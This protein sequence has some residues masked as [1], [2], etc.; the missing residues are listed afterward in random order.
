ML[1]EFVLYLSCL[2]Y[3]WVVHSIF[4]TFGKCFVSLVSSGNASYLTYPRFFVSVQFFHFFGQKRGIFRIHSYVVKTN[5]VRIF[6]RKQVSVGFWSYLFEERIFPIF[7]VSHKKSR[8]YKFWLRFGFHRIYAKMFS[9][10]VSEMKCTDTSRYR[11]FLRYGFPYL[12][13]LCKKL[14]SHEEKSG[15]FKIHSKMTDTVRSK[16]L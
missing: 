4:C 14:V 3:L 7:V 8:I 2:P 9:I 6:S 10:Y 11:D 16:Y 5:S 15:T 12:W 1:L 13:Y